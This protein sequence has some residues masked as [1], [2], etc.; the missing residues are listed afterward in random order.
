MKFIEGLDEF[1]NASR[2]RAQDAQNREFKTIQPKEY[3]STSTKATITI[4]NFLGG[5]YYLTTDEV[6]IKEGILYLIEGNT[7]AMLNSQALAILK[8]VY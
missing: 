8:M 7:L 4:K 2:L 1:M 5:L 3:L 6:E